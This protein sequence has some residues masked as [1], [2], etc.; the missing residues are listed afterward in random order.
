[1]GIGL[2]GNLGTYQMKCAMLRLKQQ[3]PIAEVKNARDAKRLEAE[4][5]IHT[6][7]VDE[8]TMQ[9]GRCFVG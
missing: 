3:I 8:L 2:K 7:E 4:R 9:T 5:T 6:D 1:M